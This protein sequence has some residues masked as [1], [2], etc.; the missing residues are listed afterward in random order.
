METG[1]V[2][3]GPAGEVMPQ[4]PPPVLAPEPIE[5]DPIPPKAGPVPWRPTA[6]ERVWVDFVEQRIPGFS[7][8]TLREVAFLFL[9]LIHI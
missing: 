6:Q 8:S 2:A 9:S 4:V 1:A 3:E 5:V 7:Q